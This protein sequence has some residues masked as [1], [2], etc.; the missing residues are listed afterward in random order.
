MSQFVLGTDE[1]AQR[2]RPQQIV[3]PI[4]LRSRESNHSGGRT[5]IF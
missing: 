5:C 2:L 1:D 3:V 4:Q